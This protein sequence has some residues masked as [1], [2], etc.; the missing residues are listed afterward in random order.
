MSNRNKAILLMVVAFGMLISG[1]ASK[2]KS[3]EEK[4]RDA[5]KKSIENSIENS[6]SKEDASTKTEGSTV[7]SKLDEINDFVTDSIWND[8]FVDIS[9]YVIDGTNSTGETMDIDFTIERLGKAM[10]QKTEYNTYIQGLD[11]KYDNLKQVWSKLSDQ[12]DILYKQLKDNPPKANDEN[13]KFDTGL[14]EQYRDAFEQ[15]VEAL[16]TK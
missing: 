14:Y 15:D 11:A 12:I 4:I 9:W 2:E 10:E 7:E 6:I 16:N 1:C 8:G 3:N 5:V 13:Y